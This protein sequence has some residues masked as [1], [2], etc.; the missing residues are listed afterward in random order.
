MINHGKLV[1][2]LTLENNLA[3]GLCAGA[4]RGVEAPL[5]Y[6]RGVLRRRPIRDGE[7]WLLLKEAAVY[8]D[9]PRYAF[10]VQ[11]SEAFRRAIQ[12]IKAATTRRRV[13]MRSCDLPSSLSDR[14]RSPVKWN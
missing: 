2:V 8:G 9:D 5:A 1:G 12:G 4:H 14:Q 6:T 3:A 7:R 13:G 11:P 10:S